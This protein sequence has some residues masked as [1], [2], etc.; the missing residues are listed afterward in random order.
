MIDSLTNK[1]PSD[2]IKVDWNEAF[3]SLL[4]VYGKDSINVLILISIVG[5]ILFVTYM[6]LRSKGFFATPL[7]KS[8]GS[9]S[10]DINA[11]RGDYISSF[12]RILDTLEDFKSDMH[13]KM[14]VDQADIVAGIM[15]TTF[16]HRFMNV[17]VDVY[18]MNHIDG[19][20][21][22]VV[23]NIKDAF[24][25]VIKESDKEFFKLPNVGGCFVDTE[26]KISAMNDE[27]I[28]EEIY[29]KMISNNNGLTM[30]RD[31]KNYLK[32]FVIQEWKLR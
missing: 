32:N 2:K 20:R 4:E 24:I 29:D 18:I 19:R 15:Q 16:I 3:S 23:K 26:Q 12:G 8:L 14:S 27:K 10:A 11:M 21:E 28:C 7:E 13:S 1:L 9:I 5:F 30:Y 6:I 31:V 22:E 17:V 25:S